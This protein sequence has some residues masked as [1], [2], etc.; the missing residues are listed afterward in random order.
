MMAAKTEIT[1]DD[2]IDMETYGQ[3]RAERRRAMMA[4]KRH[5]RIGVGPDAT[6]YFENYETMWHQVHEMLFVERG[7]EE[8]IV[9]ELAAY[10]PMIP[11][12]AELVATLMFE[13]DDEDRR[14]R[15]LDG[16]GGVENMIS[17]SVGDEV[18]AAVPEDDVERTNADGKASSVH[19]LHFPFS[20]AQI[21]KFRDPSSKIV[22]GINHPNYG[23]MAILSDDSRRALADDFAV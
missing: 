16:L 10:N 6:F 17:I 4:T 13:I 1:R 23:H 15:V 20:G 18:V 2:I 21:A 12:G 19:F 11:K 22:V 5:R 9:D 8:Q 3:A 14:K 7:G